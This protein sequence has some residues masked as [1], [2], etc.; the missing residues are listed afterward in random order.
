MANAKN[1]VIKTLRDYQRAYLSE[2]GKGIKK[3]DIAASGDLGKSF[4]I[5]Q[6]SVKMFGSTYLMKIEALPYW[7]WI[8]YGRGESEKSEGGVLK[9]KLVEWLRLPNIRQKVTKG[10]PYKDGSD[11]KW[12]EK[13]IEEVAQLMANKIHANGIKAKPFVDEARDKLD[14][15]LFKD[16]A[17]ASEEMV[18]IKL[19]EIITFINSKNQ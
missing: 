8:N 12:N 13:K 18:E 4:R 19:S 1:P 6:P 2:I 3:Y 9:D 16:I 14:N 10:K 15:K 11:D 5:G 7:Y 17:I